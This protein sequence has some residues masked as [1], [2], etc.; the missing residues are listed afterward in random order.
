MRCGGCNTQYNGKTGGSLTKTII[1]YQ[2]VAIVVFGGLTF[3]ILTYSRSASSESG[4]A[5][6]HRAW[7]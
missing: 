1:V 2:L 6:P 4:S 7:R 3:S 5:P